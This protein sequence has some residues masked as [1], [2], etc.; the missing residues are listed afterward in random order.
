MSSN[1]SFER[2][3][4]N[5]PLS[6][7]DNDTQVFRDNFDTIKTSLRVAKDEITDLQNNVVRS[8]TDNDF[9]F[10]IIQRAVFQDT[11]IKKHDGGVIGVPLVVDYQ[12]GSY[13]IFRFSADTTIEFQNFPG[14]GGAAGSA[15]KITLE[16]YSDGIDR[17]I[18]IITTNSGVAKKSDNFP[19]PFILS[20]ADLSAGI[21]N[22]VIIEVWQHNNDRIFLNYLGSFS[23]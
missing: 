10:N 8:D 3:N 19:D 6:G 11:F 12:D 7:E 22:P 2:I 21:G 18:T 17:T 15:G 20:S 16:L 4:E 13:Q 9:N 1:V 14:N 23:S 5:Y